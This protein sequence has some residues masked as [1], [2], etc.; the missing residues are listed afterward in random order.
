VPPPPPPP[1]IGINVIGHH[2]WLNSFGGWEDF[3]IDT[4]LQDPEVVNAV[5]EVQSAT[6][7]SARIAALD[8]L[9]GKIG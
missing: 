4:V 1:G 8:R 6:E 2:D 5:G 9:M 7:A 3:G